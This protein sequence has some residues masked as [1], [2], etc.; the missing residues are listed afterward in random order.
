MIDRVDL[1]RELG[2]RSLHDFV[3]MAWPLVNSPTKPFVDN[4]HIGFVCEHLEACFRGEVR[5]LIIN[6]P[7]GG[8]KSMLTSVMWPA[9]CWAL[10]PSWSSM[11]AS[12]DATLTL[13]D[14]RSMLKIVQSKWFQQ[15]W[16]SEQ[17]WNMNR[18][19]PAASDFTNSLGGWRFSTSVEGKATGRHPDVLL[20]DDPSKAQDVT[21][22]SLELATN[23]WREALSTRG[24]PKTVRKVI[25]MQRLH[26]DDL[27]GYCLREE[28]HEQW[29]HVRIPM[30]YEEA[31]P[32]VTSIGRDPRMKEGELFF[33]E[34]F[35]EDEVAKRELV[36]RASGTAAQH[37]QRPS[38]AGGLVFKRDWFK[39]YTVAPAKFDVIIQ[40]WDCAFKDAEHNDWV[41]G[42][43]WGKKGG[44]YFL[45]DQFR[46]HVTVKGTVAAIK[47]MR[48]AWPKAMTILI[49]DKANGPAV[50]QLLEKDISGLVAVTPDGGKFARA[51]A[52]S[53]LY[54]A[55][56]VYHPEAS[57]MPWIDHHQNELAA[58]PTA[59]HDDTVDASSQALNWLY[60]RTSS[61][62]AMIAG[63][64]KAG[65]LT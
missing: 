11:V 27:V 7:P 14:A 23:W 44:E 63:A 33:E 42:Q 29:E 16:N 51:S 36:L 6:V 13:R 4:W 5:R 46:E 22:N 58:F 53:A 18:G 30:R 35:P 1:E 17:T 60:Q 38:P 9:W 55:G 32:C 28:A 37:Q 31:H 21:K 26:E 10:N 19:V 65:M 12:Y 41:V 52:S 15:R 49:E 50:I 62:A 39:S 54:E 2:S 40:S 64:K 24:D 43:V 20:I 8:T 45:L 34:R 59:S 47:A 57:S 25:I 48:R 3:R 61:Y 56:N